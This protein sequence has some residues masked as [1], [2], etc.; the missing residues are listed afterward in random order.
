MQYLCNYE[1]EKLGI[2]NTG[3]VN[4]I[5]Q[6]MITDN[7][8]GNYSHAERI[9]SLNLVNLSNFT[10]KEAAS[11]LCHEVFH[12]YE[13]SIIDSADLL[14]KEHGINIVSYEPYFDSLKALISANNNYSD[15]HN[16]YE[17]YESNMLEEESRKYSQKEVP[18]LI[19]TFKWE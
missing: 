6:K 8:N 10:L 4:V 9:I 14:Y 16:N 3:P 1:M 13:H 7:V 19:E 5:A 12:T 18:E 17:T 11:T 15:D 2:K